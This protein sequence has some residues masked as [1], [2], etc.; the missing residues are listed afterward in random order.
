MYYAEKKPKGLVWKPLF[1]DYPTHNK[2]FFHTTSSA[3]LPHWQG[4]LECGSNK[5]GEFYTSFSLDEGAKNYIKDVEEQVEKIVNAKCQSWLEKP[6][7]IQSY[8]DK[9]ILFPKFS[10]KNSQIAMKMTAPNGTPYVGEACPNKME[11]INTLHNAG[12]MQLKGAAVLVAN[13]VYFN[14]QDNTYRVTFQIAYI[15]YNWEKSAVNNNAVLQAML[16]TFLG[17]PPPPPPSSDV[18]EQAALASGI[19][20]LDAED[21]DEE[22]IKKDLLSQVNKIRSTGGIVK[23]RKA[24]NKDKDLSNAIKEWCEGALAKRARLITENEAKKEEE[25]NAKMKEMMRPLQ[26]PQQA[27][28]TLVGTCVSKS[29]M[30][31]DDDDDEDEDDFEAS[32]FGE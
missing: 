2:L 9:D 29:S 26:P 15:V 14:T 28:S 30:D 6:F 25:R 27:Q 4:F 32:I 13:G 20:D 18:I 3:D 22:I 23:K 17:S 8:K 16:K 21:E 31:S 11:L 10:E 7:S 19:V 24:I 12:E 1:N 5:T